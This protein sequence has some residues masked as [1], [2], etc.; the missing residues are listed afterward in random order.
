M[1]PLSE[2]ITATLGGIGLFMI[3]ASFHFA[4]LG[5]LWMAYTALVLHALLVAAALPY[6]VRS[7]FLDVDTTTE[8]R[9]I[10]GSIS[11]FN[12]GFMWGVIQYLSLAPLFHLIVVIE[13]LPVMLMFVILYME[14]WEDKGYLAEYN[15]H[16]FY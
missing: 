1:K 15:N 4:F 16:I 10:I 5:I 8:Y 2:F 3:L 6:L 12:A 9:V 11:L 14:F 7:L 13:F